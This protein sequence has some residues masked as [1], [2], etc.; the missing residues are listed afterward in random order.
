MVHK[1][2][3]FRISSEFERNSEEILKF[4]QKKDLQNL[5]QLFLASLGTYLSGVGMNVCTIVERDGR[6]LVKDKGLD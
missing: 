3:I 2:L 1:R 5:A 6:L 4:F